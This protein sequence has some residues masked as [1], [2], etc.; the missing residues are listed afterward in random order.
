MLLEKSSLVVGELVA[1][2]LVNG[3]EIVCRL[4]E[5]K[6]D[7]YVLERPCVVVGGAKGIGLIQAMFSMDPTKNITVG[8]SHVMMHCEVI[9]AMRNHYIEVTTGIQTVNNGGIIT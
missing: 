7:E 5:I 2:K 1:L 8:K 3:D 6:D 4:S 9:E